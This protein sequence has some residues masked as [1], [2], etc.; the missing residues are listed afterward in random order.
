MLQEPNLGKQ[1]DG[2]PHEAVSYLTQKTFRER[3]QNLDQTVQNDSHFRQEVEVYDVRNS[4]N[5]VILRIHPSVFWKSTLC[6][7]ISLTLPLVM[8]L[9]L[10]RI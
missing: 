3:L 10:Q 2:L 7:P 5:S 9:G 1:W 8:T 4:L 6:A